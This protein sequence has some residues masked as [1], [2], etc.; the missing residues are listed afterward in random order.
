MLC[1]F[2]ITDRLLETTT[3]HTPSPAHHNVVVV[4]Q[5]TETSESTF[6]LTFTEESDSDTTFDESDSHSITVTNPHS[7]DNTTTGILRQRMV[8]G[9]G[10]H[11]MEDEDT[12]ETVVSKA[13]ITVL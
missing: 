11:T 12:A 1:I 8:A 5:E 4:D 13:I 2:Y 10:E 9:D 3:N 6:N 7:N